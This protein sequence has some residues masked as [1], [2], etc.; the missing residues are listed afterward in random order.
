M[1]RQWRIG[2]WTLFILLFGVGGFPIGAWAGGSEGK[3]EGFADVP[4][5][6]APGDS[7]TLPLPP[8]ASPV[9]INVNLGTPTVSVPVV[10]T[11]STEIETE[12][13][14]PLPI[15]LTDGD[16]VKVE[17]EIVGT[18]IVADKLE[19]A[20]FPEVEVRCIVSGV[21]G[22]SLG[23]PLGATASPVTVTCTLDASGVAF[24]I[25]ITNSTRVEGG[26]FLL[27]NGA[28]VEI[29]AI[30]MNGQVTVTE[31]KLED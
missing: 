3:I 7:L 16:R 9:T 20:D 6:G 19:L 15:T 5:L 29:E 11:P 10:I 24:P 17:F 26:S 31:I 28:L 1:H 30:V 12:E 8:G 2:I 4:P 21:P 14:I 23:L 22:G 18:A 27:V 13:G 25:T